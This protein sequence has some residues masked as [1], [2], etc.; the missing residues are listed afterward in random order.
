MLEIIAII[1]AL[2]ITIYI[3]LLT[4]GIIIDFFRTKARNS[5]IK[6]TFQEKMKN[7]NYKTIAVGLNSNHDVEKY[8]AYES[9]DIDSDLYN[10]HYGNELIIWT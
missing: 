4:I 10:A 2:A 1:I 9:S 3:V 5:K 8:D 6:A 7:G